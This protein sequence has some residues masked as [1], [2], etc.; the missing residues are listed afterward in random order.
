VEGRLGKFGAVTNRFSCLRH[1]EWKAPKSPHHVTV[2][3]QNGRLLFFSLF[4]RESWRAVFLGELK[5]FPLATKFHQSIRLPVS[6]TPEGKETK[7]KTNFGGFRTVAPQ[8]SAKT[9]FGMAA[10]RVKRRN[11]A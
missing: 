9:V 8:P 5:V 1:G 4:G 2:A 3:C 7:A 6:V 11:Q 10:L